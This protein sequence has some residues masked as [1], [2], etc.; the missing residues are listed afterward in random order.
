MAMGVPTILGIALT[1][2]N[3]VL[4][5][6][7]SLVW[8]RNYRQF[9]STMVLGLLGFCLVLLVENLVG[10]VFFLSSMNMLYA[11]DPIAGQVALGMHL[12]ELIA[13]SFLTYVTLK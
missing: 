1:A 2:V 5:T 9:R 10:L 13:V 4:L 3:S 12:L 7:I 8:L 11:A 6:V